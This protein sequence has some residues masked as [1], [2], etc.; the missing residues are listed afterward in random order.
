MVTVG[1]VGR[2]AKI[3]GVSSMMALMWLTR[4]W[5]TAKA[6]RVGC[7]FGVY[8]VVVVVVAGEGEGL[9]M[10]CEGVVGGFGVAIVIGGPVGPVGGGRR[11]EDLRGDVFTIGGRVPLQEVEVGRIANELSVIQAETHGVPDP[12]GLELVGYHDL[13]GGILVGVRGFRAG[14]MRGREE[15]RDGVGDSGGETRMG[16]GIQQKNG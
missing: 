9:V 11:C 14:K 15:R 6:A 7:V 13:D 10:V 2:V 8:I 5:R 1:V 3:D 4:T 12:E 16:I